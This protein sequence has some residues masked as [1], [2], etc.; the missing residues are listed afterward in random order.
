VNLAEMAEDRRRWP[1]QRIFSIE[2][3]FEQSKSRLSAFNGPAHA[4][5]KE[6]YPL[7][8]DIFPLLACLT[9]KLS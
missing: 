2:C 6:R 9:W 7:K 5:V 3:R 1:T 4:G 8:V